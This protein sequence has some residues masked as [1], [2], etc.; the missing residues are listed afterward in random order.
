MDRINTCINIMS[1]YNRI[2]NTAAAFTRRARGIFE[3]TQFNEMAFPTWL[4]G[5]IKKI[6]IIFQTL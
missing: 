6:N 2:R 3:T 5:R 4:H 1:Q